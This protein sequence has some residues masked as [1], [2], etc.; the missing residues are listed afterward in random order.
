MSSPKEAT[1]KPQPL[2][3][4]QLAASPHELILGEPAR[5]EQLADPSQHSWFL[6]PNGEVLPRC[7]GSPG[8]SAENGQPSPPK[9][10]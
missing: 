3:Q 2:P 4:P 5:L 9:L 1:S 8:E 6:A 10:S 7:A